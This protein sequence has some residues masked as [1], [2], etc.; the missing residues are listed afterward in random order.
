MTGQLRLLFASGKGHPLA[1][2]ELAIIEPLQEMGYAAI[3]EAMSR[4][5]F[6]LS[7]RVSTEIQALVPQRRGSAE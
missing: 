3:A 4:A 2:G 5:L 1:S 7:R 6:E